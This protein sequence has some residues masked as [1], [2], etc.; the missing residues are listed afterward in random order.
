MNLQKFADSDERFARRY[1]YDDAIVVAADL[2]FTDADVDV[3]DD[4]VIVVGPED[5]QFELDVSA[6]PTQVFMRNGVLTIEME[7]HQ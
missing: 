6:T 2:E 1:V 7:D 4:T 3:V 5:E